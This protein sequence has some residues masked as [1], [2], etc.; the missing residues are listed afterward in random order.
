MVLGV[1]QTLPQ[2]EVLN[3]SKSKATNMIAFISWWA[4]RGRINL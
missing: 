1:T 2:K 4:C 3:Y